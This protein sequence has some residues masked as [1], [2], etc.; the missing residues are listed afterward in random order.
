MQN[1]FGIIRIF[2]ILSDAKDVATLT[3]VVVNILIATLISELGHF[4]L[5]RSELLI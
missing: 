2:D 1:G 3:N 4:D 5:F